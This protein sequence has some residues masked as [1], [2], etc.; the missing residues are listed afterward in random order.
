M[1]EQAVTNLVRMITNGQRPLT[2]RLELAALLSTMPDA[3]EACTDLLDMLS[4][5]T[6][7]G[8]GFREVLVT[9]GASIDALCVLLWESAT[10][11]RAA[12]DRLAELGDSS[13]L[14]DLIALLRTLRDQ[15]SRDLTGIIRALE[16]IG[17]CWVPG[18]L[19][20][21]VAVAE[22]M[23][24][25][26]ATV[27]TVASANLRRMGTD[28]TA[29]AELLLRLLASAHPPVRFAVAE[30]L[31]ELVPPTVY[32]PCMVR[33]LQEDE[34]ELIRWVARYELSRLSATDPQVAEAL[35]A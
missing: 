33:L 34:D 21:P 8:A 30:L 14:P 18:A 26:D 29:A 6:D 25:L 19:E 31:P 16:V 1:M 28:A 15:P 11:R 27:R 17:S 13:A 32:V 2:R 10:V 20:A 4:P 22:A 24:D 5:D 3:D 35:A 9:V 23:G 7:I 12:L